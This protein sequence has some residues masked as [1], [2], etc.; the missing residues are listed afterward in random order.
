M[1]IRNF[2][3]NIILIN[4]LFII[5]TYADI[6]LIPEPVF[7]T[8]K[9]G[10]FILN[11]ETDIYINGANSAETDE[12]EEIAKL[13]KSYIEIPVG[14]NFEIIKSGDYGSNDIYLTTSSDESVLG[15]EGY[16][17]D[18][19]S[20][21][22]IIKAFKPEGVF[23]G[24]NTLRQLLP[25]QIEKNL[26]Q[27]SVEWKVEGISITDYPRYG[28]RSYM[29]DPARNW[30]TVD[31]VK[32]EIDRM[33]LYKYNI[34]H[35]HLTDDQGWRIEIDGWP[36]LT[37]IASDNDASAEGEPDGPGVGP[38]FY[39]QADFSEI[40]EYADARYIEVVPEV[41]FPGHTNSM[42]YAYPDELLGVSSHPKWS[43]IGVHESEFD[44]YSETAWK[45]I[46]DV[47]GQVHKLTNTKFFHIG[48]D[49][50]VGITHAEYVIAM[51][52]AKNIADSIGD[53]TLIGWDEMAGSNLSGEDIYAQYWHSASN[54][55]AA[56][57]KGMPIIMSPAER[58]YLDIVY[59]FG[60]RTPEDCGLTWI[61]GN[62][63]E[64][65]YD[66]DPLTISW[67][68]TEE[69]IAGIE[70]PLWGETIENQKHLEILTYPRLLGGGEIGWSQKEKRNWEDYKVR[71]GKHALRMDAMGIGFY[72]SPSVPW[73]W[74]DTPIGEKYLNKIS[75]STKINI[76]QSSKEI[77]FSS[78]SFESIKIYD[79]K[80]CLIKT[81]NQDVRKWNIKNT[82]AGFYVVKLIIDGN[83]IDR[84]VLISR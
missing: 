45:L 51:D 32:T 27:P 56:A 13:F 19:E 84:K 59:S 38:R 30:L 72:E 10:S 49:E 31:Q 41:D 79:L 4:F 75:S 12:L 6:A 73:D 69:D 21:N 65:A 24:I 67:G 44:V 39:T 1:K 58:I 62:S 20:D 42:I 61:K 52:K 18:A 48:G 64:D 34:L 16:K 47:M 33:A 43:G 55:V 5:S 57:K 22:C 7:K 3:F 81:M 50:A 35:L 8:S 63:V 77:T 26:K 11:A 80:G 29:L 17:L 28:Y 46:A 37:T 15:D 71:L 9:T 83:Q 76:I 74:D 23:R 25:W 53:M 14:L 68:L 36:K 2:Y 54:A 66:W 60:P 70:V 82:P 40:V 78:S